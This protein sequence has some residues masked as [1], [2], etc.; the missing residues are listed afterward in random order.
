[1]SAAPAATQIDEILRVE[2]LHVS[3]P[4]RRAGVGRRRMLHAVRGVNLSVRRG[5]TFAL[6]GE[7]GCGKT[8]L[9]RTILG[10][11]KPSRG[12]VLLNGEDLTSM[13]SR[14]LRSRRPR[15][16][17]VFQDPYSS[18]DPR[19]TVNEIIAE[20]LRIN[21]RYRPERIDEL[22]EYVGMTPEVKKRLPS[23]FSGGQRQRIGIARAL[24]LEPHLLILDEPVSSLD[25]SIQAQVI[26]LLRELQSRLGLTCLLIAH[27]LSV[28]RYMSHQIAA[29]Y[30]GE[31][32]EIGTARQ[33]FETP[34]H[35]YTQS[36]IAAAPV[37]RP[38]GREQRRLAPVLGDMPDPT[39]PPSG[40]SFRTRCPRAKEKCA[41]DDPPLMPSEAP[42]HE[43]SCWFAGPAEYFLEAGSVPAPETPLGT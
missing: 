17:V 41:V 25:V 30:L 33:I 8:T 24:A 37:P 27:D 28:V 26:N 20:P 36:L 7:S 29:M 2:D 32:V 35:P 31:I 4:I 21:D 11:Q 13:S 18:L 40:C 19:M 9:A 15:M 39:S 38:E 34:Q 5:Q 10:L 3:F 12:R 1:M 43:A 23:E 6:V 14:E 42:G 16:Q 22:L